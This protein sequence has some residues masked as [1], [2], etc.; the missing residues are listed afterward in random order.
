[1]T[2]W[3]NRHD[4]EEILTMPLAMEA[5]EEGFRQLAL[6]KVVMPQRTVTPV[7]SCN[8]LHLSMPAFVEGDP[9]ALAVKILTVFND[10]LPRYGLPT[11]L[12]HLLVHDPRTGQLLA[13]MDA[14]ALTAMR[15][16]AVSGLATRLLARPEARVVAL[17]GVGAQ[18]GPQLEGVCAVRPIERAWVVSGNDRRETAFCQLQEKKLGIPVRLATS[19]EEAV[20]AAD[21]ICTATNSRD[22]VFRGE[23]LRPG[24]HINAIGAYTPW[25]RELDETTVCCSRVFI[26]Q[27]QAAE[28]EAGDL[29]IAA[30]DGRWSLDQVAGELG[31][32]LLG[33]VTGRT[34]Q[35]EITLFKSVGLA[36]Q[37]AV[38]AA[39]VY[40]QAVDRGIGQ[41]IS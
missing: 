31:E 12:A 33:K 1:M 18:G 9:G 39:R 41:T 32:L 38:T 14:E 25:M 8:G 26:D 28:A 3:L 11:I 35:E 20:K 37:D 19:P 5:V 7:P 13:I 4:V 29:L 10:N 16:G 15:T 6:G 17:F 24:T 23:W 2:M 21:V 40:A 22:P 36:L 30:A 34:N 27:R